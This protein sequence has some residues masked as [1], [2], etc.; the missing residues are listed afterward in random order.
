MF[1][2]IKESPFYQAV[3]FSVPRVFRVGKGLFSVIVFTQAITA[4]LAPTTALLLGKMALTV[5]EMLSRSSTDLAPLIPWILIAT[6]IS[7]IAAGCRIARR[8]CTSCLNDR[9]TLSM[10]HE[11]VRHI[12]SLNLEMIE[13]RNVLDILERGQQSPGANMLNFT[14][15]F[16]SIASTLLRIT[17]L[18]G[19]LF[20]VSPLWSTLIV[21]LGIPA[22][23]GNRYL[24]R[25]NFKIRR[26]KTTARRWS[27]Y[28]TGSL[29]N[30]GMI[31]TVATLGIT[32]LFL[33]RFDETMLDINA[34]RRKFYRLR[35]KVMLGAT[36]LMAGTLIAALLTVA[37][38]ASAGL[39]H[40]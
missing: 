35:S 12:T 28:Y 29:T 18:V 2:Q 23:I 15:G 39:I 25:I 27:R 4:L 9:M 1:Q 7:V 6:S 24:S 37:K 16:I 21:L 13:D 20:W 10:Q 32:D 33:K 31:P 17:T 30:R 22:L 14:T 5:K 34:V 40:I 26:S 11:V 38:D 3:V 8:Y 36:L 19:V